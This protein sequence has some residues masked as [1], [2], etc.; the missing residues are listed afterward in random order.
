MAHYQ[1]LTRSFRPQ[2]FKE[3]CGQSAIVSTLKNAVALQRVSHAYLFSGPR[4]VGKTT[5]LNK[6]LGTSLKT[7]DVVTKTYKGAHTTT[8]AQLLP[9]TP[10]G[11]CI[12]TPG[13]KSFGIWKNEPKDLQYYFS[14]FTPFALHCKYPCCL[15]LEEPECAVKN[16]VETGEISSMRY[17][18]YYNLMTVSEDEHR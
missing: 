9:L 6:L 4:G 16:A 7:S 10:S 15:H 2:A 12:D 18:S 3:V 17:Q 14:E 1:S 13:I 8:M 5:L 11:F